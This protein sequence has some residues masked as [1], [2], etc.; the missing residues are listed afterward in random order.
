MRTCVIEDF[1]IKKNVVE[2]KWISLLLGKVMLPNFFGLCF[3]CESWDTKLEER[4]EALPCEEILGAIVFWFL[5]WPLCGSG[6]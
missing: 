2:R 5:V 3:T 6:R 1:S 4:V